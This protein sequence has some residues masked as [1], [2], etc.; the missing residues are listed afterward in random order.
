MVK[1]QFWSTMTVTLDV[2]VAFEA[3]EAAEAAQATEA[4]EA[5]LKKAMPTC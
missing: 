4:G 2:T 5:D 3:A 1:H